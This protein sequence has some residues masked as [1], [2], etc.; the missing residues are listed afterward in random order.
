[1][2]NMVDLREDGVLWAINKVLF[3][4]RGYALSLL[5]DGTFE[6]LGDGSEAWQFSLDIEHGSFVKFE[7]LLERAKFPSSV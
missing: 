4:P 3:H 6:L 2:R 1:M 5:P 7:S